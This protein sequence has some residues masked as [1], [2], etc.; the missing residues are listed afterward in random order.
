VLF[1]VD[2]IVVGSTQALLHAT[3]DGSGE[4]VHLYLDGD[5]DVLGRAEMP[6]AYFPHDGGLTVAECRQLLAALLADPR[7]RVIEVAELAARDADRRYASLVVDMLASA[8]SA[9][10]TGAATG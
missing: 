6:A 5:V 10:R 2:C 4:E 7:I 8:S 3:G 1:G 9:R